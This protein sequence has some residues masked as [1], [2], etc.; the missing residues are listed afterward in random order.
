M[1][2]GGRRLAMMAVTL[3]VVLSLGEHWPLPALL[4]LAIAACACVATMDI[5]LE[6][7][8]VETVPAAERAFVAS[9]LTALDR[10]TPVAITDDFGGA[11]AGRI[12]T[13][14]FRS[15]SRE[16]GV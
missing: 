5:A 9:A 8:V 11:I 2:H 1:T 7:L 15:R 14:R 10:C 3:L 13:V 12:L 4:A 6:A 16:T